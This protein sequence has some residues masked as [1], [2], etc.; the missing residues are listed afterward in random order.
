MGFNHIL[1]LNA[2]KVSKSLILS[3]AENEENKTFKLNCVLGW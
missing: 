1:E 3:H 2:L